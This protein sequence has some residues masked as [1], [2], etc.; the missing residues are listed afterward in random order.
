MRVLGESPQDVESGLRQLRGWVGL[1]KLAR[2]PSLG[3]EKKS[4][5]GGEA[6]FLPKRNTCR[7]AIRKRL[8]HFQG[9]DG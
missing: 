3:G 4:E 9:A 2:K 1:T 6:G 5:R 8:D 7:M